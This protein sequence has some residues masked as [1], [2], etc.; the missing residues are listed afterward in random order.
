[1]EKL[2][3][4]GTS[5][6]RGKAKT[7]MTIKLALKLGLT[8]ASF[9]GNEGTVIVGRD[10]RCFAEVLSKGVVSGLVSGGINVEDCGVAPTPAIL[11]ALKKRKL[12]GGIVITGSHT[13]K[14]FIGFLFFLKDTSE[15]SDQ[16]AIQFENKFFAEIKRNTS[17]K[18]G[19]ILQIDI[20][21]I[22]LESLIKQ[23]NI[24]N[25]K[26]NDYKIALDPGN[27]AA[28]N[29]Y[30]EI[31][32]ILGIKKIAINDKPNGLF[33][34][35]DPYPRPGNLA[36]LSKIIKQEKADFGSACDGDGDRAIFADNSG[37][38][39]WG[40]ISGA[41][42]AK[43]ELKKH[44]GGV[45]VTP[46]NSS[47]LINWVCDNN[48]GE[49]FFTKI[50]PPAIVETMKR[51]EAI[52]GLEETGKIIWPNSI[53]YGDWMLATI[54]MLEIIMEQKK[55]LYEIKQ[56]FPH[57]HMKKEAFYCNNNQKIKVLN[58]VV[59]K[60]K[61]RNEKIE[62]VTIDGVRINYEDNSWILF[63]P[64]GTES[65]FRMYTESKDVKKV[66]QLAKTGSRIIKETIQKY[67]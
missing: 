13:P 58:E 62:I 27:G 38:V 24:H 30:S 65:V 5:G 53:Y 44:N 45:I 43:K 4:F 17:H 41:I 37:E 3:L 39:L 50:G 35:R 36:D 60:W 10:V 55:C 23:I 22:Y 48:N 26:L 25:K 9:L 34:N 11:W 15:L 61:K 6:I 12:D 28:S 59:R 20:S 56:D 32:E 64:S 49:V 66:E 7:E 8:F 16:G 18:V 2:K 31:F 67:N 52:I 19:K 33:P 63:K 57:F 14:E 42:F 21:K 40:D 46:I 29:Y 1:M 47:Q 54:N 51:E